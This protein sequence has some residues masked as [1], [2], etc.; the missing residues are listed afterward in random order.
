[1]YKN[2]SLLSAFISV[3]KLDIICLSE[4]YLNSETYPNDENLEIPAYNIIRKYY[5]SSTKRGEFP[6][7][8]TAH[9]H[10]N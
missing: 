8:I 6:L 10:L 5:P 1:M 7:I 2:L 3:C 4:T 9:Y